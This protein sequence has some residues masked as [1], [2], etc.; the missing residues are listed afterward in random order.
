MD[1]KVARAIAIDGLTLTPVKAA[2]FDKDFAGF[3]TARRMVS[4]F[5][6]T[7]LMNEKLLINNVVILLNVFGAQKT[8]GVFRVIMDDVQFS[9][10][11]AILMWLRQYDS[12][13][14]EEVY[15]NRIMVDILRDM[16]Q[17]YN[18]DHL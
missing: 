3:S 4:R 13:V 2:E 5:L 18:L 8:T 16:N 14:S 17:R 10:V 7:G 6:N 12:T 1:F 15:P 9:V 11:K